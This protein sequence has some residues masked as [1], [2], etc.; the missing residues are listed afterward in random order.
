MGRQLCRVC[1]S[2]SSAVVAHRRHLIAPLS[3]FGVTSIQA[4]TYYRRYPNDT[5]FLKGLVSTF[6]ENQ[7]I[8]TITDPYSLLQVLFLWF[9]DCQPDVE[10]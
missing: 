4:I 1:V 9:V 7:F 6:H 8:S 10:W 5:L 3:F 2:A